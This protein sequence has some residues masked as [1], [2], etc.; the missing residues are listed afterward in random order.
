M[1][2]RPYTDQDP[3]TMIM[4]WNEVVE[5]GNAFPQTEPLTRDTA[6]T[7]F[8][9]Q[10]LSAVAD[11]GQV[12]GLYILHPNNVGRCGHIAN[13]SFAVSLSAMRSDGLRIMV[14]GV[15]NLMPS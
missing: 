14:F 3:D 5:A 7:F 9:E 8:A 10:S 11:D 13:A 15:F 6:E 4:L 2:I 12:V 1:V